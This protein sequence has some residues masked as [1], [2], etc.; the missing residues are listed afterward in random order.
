M[1][2]LD[3]MLKGAIRS[4]EIS[5]EKK[6]KKIENHKQFCKQCKKPISYEK[7]RNVFCSS[8]CAILDH[9]P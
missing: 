6:L 9:N 3:L 5:H 4:G 1:I 2:R 7:R 8:R